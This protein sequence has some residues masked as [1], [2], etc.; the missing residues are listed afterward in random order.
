MIIHIEIQNRT[1]L[2]RIKSLLCK[3]LIAAC[4]GNKDGLNIASKCTQVDYS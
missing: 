3:A 1:Q 4:N 2:K